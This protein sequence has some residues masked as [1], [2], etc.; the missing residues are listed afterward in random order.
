MFEHAFSNPLFNEIGE[1]V[2]FGLFGLILLSGLVMFGC[3][4]YLLVRGS[5]AKT[6]PSAIDRAVEE[7]LDRQRCLEI[8]RFGY[9]LNH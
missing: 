6:S 8:S 9:A 7:A 2:F 3:W 5:K 1:V 4:G